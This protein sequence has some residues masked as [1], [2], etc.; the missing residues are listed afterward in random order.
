M[1]M[2]FPTDACNSCSPAV[3]PAIDP[4][5][6]TPL[7]L[8]TVLGLQA[9][10]I[11]PAFFASPAAMAQRLVRAKAKLRDAGI[12]F[13]LPDASV[14]GER[15]HAVLEALYA[16]YGHVHDAGPGADADPALRDLR[17][18]LLHLAGLVVALA[19]AEAEAM[20]L[21]ALMWFCEARR[22]ASPGAEFVPLHERDA[23]RWNRRLLAQAD[24]LLWQ[25]SALRA[26]GP[27]QLEAAI[28]SAHSQRAY[29]GVVPWDA[30]VV[31]YG[32]LLQLA[33]TL[34][35]RIG[36]AVALAKSGR[37]TDAQSRLDAIDPAECATYQPYWVAM[38]HVLSASGD[39]SRAVAALERAVALTESE[40][41]RRF[42][43]RG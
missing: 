12:P 43:L 41:L 9:K 23:S 2:P 7:M 27:F 40:S 26:P 4:A 11:A 21:L 32:H 31:L 10:D 34:G 39:A 1:R 22:E 16:G 8:Q 15:I 13:E 3:T 42:L 38:A 35:A 28:Q 18:E 5:L 36:H 6:R 20:G 29:T 17:G 30:I 25:A 14:L 24:G 33:P 37:V 19:P